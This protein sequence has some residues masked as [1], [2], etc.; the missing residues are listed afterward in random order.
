MNKTF[1]ML[2]REI[3]KEHYLE[4]VQAAFL[5]KDA[6][7]RLPRDEEFKREFT[8]KDVYNFRSR[9][10]LLRKIEDFRHQKQLINIE[11]YT[12]EHILPQNPHLSLEWQ[13]ELG[14]NWTDIQARYLHTIGNLTLTPYNTELGDLPFQKKRDANPGGFK[15]TPLWLNEY[16]AQLE[17]WGELEIQQRAAKL[18]EQAVQVWSIPHMSLEQINMYSKKAPM[19]ILAEIIGPL[20]HPLAGFIPAGFK[21]TQV[22]QKKWYYFRQIEGQ[23]VHYG[24]GKDP[25]YTL[26]WESAGRYLRDYNKKNTMPLGAGGSLHP[27]YGGEIEQDIL[28]DNAD[29]EEA[30]IL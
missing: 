1:A 15:H 22:G 29:R 8:V 19:P 6:T 11:T 2:A 4:S 12:I 10:Y 18:V 7:R 23:W 13:N 20:D 5:E 3:D 21:I 26:S 30:D 27:S 24:N 16:L 9:N 28:T 14:P 17:H 25:W